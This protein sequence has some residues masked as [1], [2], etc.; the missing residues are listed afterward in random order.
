[1]G[2]LVT[3]VNTALSITTVKM[4]VILPADDRYLFSINKCVPAM[5]VGIDRAYRLGILDKNQVVFNIRDKDSGCNGVDAPLAAFDYVTNKLADIYFGPCCDYSL[6]PVA[7][8][9]K[10]WNIPVITPGGFA[11][12]FAQKQGEAEFSMLTRVGTNFDSLSDG[13]I[14]IVEENSWKSV[15]IIYDSDGQ[16][17]VSLGF[18]HLAISALIRGMI[19]SKIS[20]E[21]IRMEQDKLNGTEDNFSA[22]GL[23][24]NKIGIKFGG[25][26][27]NHLFIV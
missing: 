6:A 15:M 17:S 2:F 14:K 19:E 4:G 20:V 8:Y 10:H 5:W 27:N 16:N 24:R 26:Y 11:T 18:C 7:R 12:D 25:K 3:M 9:S 21:F 1:M 23:L 13:A 22:G